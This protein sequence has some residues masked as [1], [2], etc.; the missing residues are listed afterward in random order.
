MKKHMITALA[1]ALSCALLSGCVSDSVRDEQKAERQALANKQQADR[2]VDRAQKE[3]AGSALALEVSEAN[4]AAK[5]QKQA[6]ADAALQQVLNPG[7][8]PATK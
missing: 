3:V 7:P 5:K 1:A 8:V 6:E 2:Q 4:L